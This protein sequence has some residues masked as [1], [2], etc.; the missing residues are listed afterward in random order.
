SIQDTGYTVYPI[1]QAFLD[2]VLVIT[3][4]TDVT[5][6]PTAGGAVVYTLT[7][8][9]FDFGPLT[10]LEVWDLLPPGV[11]TADYLPGSTLVTYPD[12]SQDTTDPT[13]SIDPATSRDRLDWTLSPDTL[14]A[15]RTLTVRYTVN[16][17]T[18]PIGLL[19]NEAHA[20]ATLGGSVFAPFDTADVVRTDVSLGKLVSDLDPEAGDTLTFTLEVTNGGA[21]DE[22]NVV[23]TD[24]VPPDATFSAGGIVDAGP[25]TGTYDP[26]QNAVVWTAALFG[27]G[28]GPFS[29][30]FDVV[31]NPG[32]PAGT[33]IA[34]RGSYES[35][36]TPYFLS[37]EV[38]PVVIGPDLA[39]SKTG[40]ALLHP[41]EVAA[42][43]IQVENSGSGTTNVLVVAD[44]FP[45]NTTYV[46]GSMEW[47]LNADPFV[48]VTDAA[49]ADEGTA[50]VDRV[51]LAVAVLGPGEDL[52]F[53]FR[54]RVDPGTDGQ[55]VNNQATVSST[56]VPPTDTNLLAVPIVGD[57]DLTG[58]VFLDLDGSG[59]Q[60][61][62]E[63]DLANVDVLVI[64]A[65]GNPQIATTDSNGDY[66]VTVEPGLASLNVDETD[67]DFPAGALL[68][69]ANDPQNVVAVS[70]V[71]AAATAVGYQPPALSF[72]K[73]SDAVG[74][75]VVQGQT[76]TYT[77]DLVNNTAVNQTGI[78]VT[79]P[80]PAGTLAVPGST[81]VAIS[82][83]VARVTEYFLPVGTFS[84]TTYDLTLNQNLAADYFV[85]VQGSDGDGSDSN[86]RGPAENYAALT[87]DPFAT[88][89]LAASGAADVIRIER[90]NAVD[91]WVGVL[92][93]VEC[94]RDCANDGFTLLD[95]RRVDHA[96]ATGAGSVAS[97][98]AWPDINQVMLM[99]GFNGAG[100]NTAEA[101]AANTKVCHAR[102]YP[103][104][105]NQIN[106]TRDA[107][108]ATL[109]QASSTVM[110]VE[111]GSAWTVQRAQ[112]TGNNGGDGVDAVGEYNTAAIAGVARANTWVWG[113]GH[114]D[115]QGIGDAAEAVV[116][117]LGDGVTQNAT[118]TQVAAGI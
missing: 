29:L 96:G 89:Q 46:A 6:V 67:A 12:L 56:E 16:I 113:T 51:E 34:N 111:W 38:D 86:N 81:Q 45:T 31:V 100:C 116:L 87:R 30:S 90:G 110:V 5:T 37:N 53:R 71:P 14:D 82:N 114:T 103:S 78:A 118:E 19:T 24:P 101:G 117:T 42:F 52:T 13:P 44:P 22:T 72:V 61:P 40:P 66:L 3:K 115:D 98:V 59:V 1:N 54:I 62:G 26:A 27:A 15:N 74:G 106:W 48:A 28:T 7:V 75:E 104:G 109:S 108:G 112:V 33:V 39:I 76:L 92:T 65:M 47:Q 70:G 88:G 60:D 2:P 35:T 57:A 93:V 91:S 43:E 9:S 36:E 102:I 41:N 84:G 94:L 80:L 23:V 49:D 20:L 85:I 50:F 99:G 25:F 21:T 32:V 4:E 95:V 63:P 17:P 64:D 77:L 107:G 18:G 83:D 68:T 8:E 55:F 105:G 58:H 10:N 73:A 97:A 79:D 69:T 11:T